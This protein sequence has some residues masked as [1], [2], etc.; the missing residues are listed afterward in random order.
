VDVIYETIKFLV[1]AVP[2]GAPSVD[3]YYAR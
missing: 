3:P 2:P 1:I